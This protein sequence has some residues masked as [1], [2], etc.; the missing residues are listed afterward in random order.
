ME[1]YIHIDKKK[2]K[3]EEDICNLISRQDGDGEKESSERRCDICVGESYG[4]NC[5]PRFCIY[6]FI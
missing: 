5:S 1:R 4:S 3:D 6:L 2:N